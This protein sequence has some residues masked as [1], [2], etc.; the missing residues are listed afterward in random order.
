MFTYDPPDAINDIAFSATIGPNDAGYTFI[1]IQYGF[2]GKTLKS[3]D[4]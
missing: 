3:F 2:I 1:K 4:F